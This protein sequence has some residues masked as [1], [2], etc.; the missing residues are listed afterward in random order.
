MRGQQLQ[1]TARTVSGGGFDPSVQQWTVLLGN[2]YST[3]SLFSPY[4]LVFNTDVSKC[5]QDFSLLLVGAGVEVR[6][7]FQLI[8]MDK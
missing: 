3:V 4:A 7:S 8:L 2:T 5:L 1:L 6:G